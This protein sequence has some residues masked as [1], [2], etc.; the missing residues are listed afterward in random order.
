MAKRPLTYCSLLIAVLSFS[1]GCPSDPSHRGTSDRFATPSKSQIVSTVSYPL[2][3]MTKRLIGNTK[4]GV[5]LIGSPTEATENWTPNDSQIQTLQQSDLIIANGPGAP[6]AQWMVRVSLPESRIV[7]TTDDLN[8]DEF[9]MI[10]DYQ[11]VHQHGPEGEHS[12]PFMVAQS[13]LDPQI[14]GKQAVQ[15]ATAL[16]TTYPDLSATFDE[17]LQRLSQ[18][19]TE[20]SQRTASLPEREILSSTPRLKFLTRA[21]GLKDTHLLWFDFPEES[22]WPITGEKEFLERASQ[23]RSKQ[24]LFDTTPPAWLITKLEKLGYRPLYLNSFIQSQIP[25]EADSDFLSIMEDNLQ[26][27]QNAVVK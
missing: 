4:I 25:K 2:Y 20:L 5:E 17:N 23:S 12:H 6:F 19:L 18:E 15:I 24:I 22:A 21:A 26:T 9:I 27:L 8:L 14:A 10:K 3:Y 11:V 13:W 1:A 7:H 16:K